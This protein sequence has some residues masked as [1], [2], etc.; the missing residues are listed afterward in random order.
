MQI[1]F[2]VSPDRVSFALEVLL[3][4]A[5]A[6]NPVLMENAAAPN[7]T[8]DYLLSSLANAGRLRLAYEQ[9][10]WGERLDSRRPPNEF[11]AHVS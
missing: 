8:T 9:F 10:G 1:V 3:S 4:I 6:Q 7:D 5:F 2:D 11:R